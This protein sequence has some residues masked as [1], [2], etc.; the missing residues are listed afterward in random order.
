MEGGGREAGGSPVR[1]AVEAVS[2][3]AR[4]GRLRIRGIDVET[5]TFMPVG[6]AGTV[7]GLGPDEVAATGARIVLGNTFHLLSRPGVEVVAAHG[8]LHR[9][10]G[11]EGGILTDSGGFQ[12]F[13]LS[14]LRKLDD[15]GVTFASPVDGASMRLT[16]E[17]AVA[18]QA[19]LGSDIAMVLDECPPARAP[20]AEV[21]R[22][23]RRTTAWARRSL[24]APR[25]AG[26]ALFAIVQGALW[27]DLRRSHL[28]ELAA[29]P[30]DGLA[31]GG[32]S[33]GESPERRWPVLAEIGPRMPA[34]R[35][36]YLMGL[37]TPLDLFHAAASG[38]D[39]FDCVLP[40][41]N[42]RNGQAFTA[43]GRI[44]IKQA[45][46]RND[47]EPLERDCPCPA[48]T[49]FTRAY[50]RH[51]YACGEILSA[52]LLTAHNLAFFARWME[53]MRA[54][55]RRGTLEGLEAEARRAT[56][57]FEGGERGGADQRGAVS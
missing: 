20:R 34:D 10:M 56:G 31:L 47:L 11:W 12:V 37:G 15:D 27:E 3:T 52:R 26:Q 1:I 5:P 9:F 29:L 49:R 43:A 46:F 16:P 7:K 36:R 25:G 44:A 30:F 45:R 4:V 28:E 40:T 39:M 35:P 53:R 21:E 6:T 50:L 33:V 51:L 8:G 17:S 38:I 24:G 48:C 41:R 13:S 57:P 42:A 22:A 18:A 2:G 55:I 19:A 32:F 23:V 54:A 14:A